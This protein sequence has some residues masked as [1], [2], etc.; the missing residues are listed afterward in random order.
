MR[1]HESLC[2][3]CD[4]ESGSLPPPSHPTKAYAEVPFEGAWARAMH[5]FKYRGQLA[6]AGPLGRRWALSPRWAEPWEAIVPIP[7]HW[8]RRVWRGFNQVELL[9][10]ATARARPDVGARVRPA[11]LKRARHGPAQARLSAEARSQAAEGAFVVP[12][13]CYA[14]VQGRR[15]LVVDDVITTGS[16]LRAA[17]WAL[18]A[19]GAQA[20]AGMALMQAL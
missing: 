6:L 8:R 1:P 10:Q 19:A 12:A 13:S 16:T 5:A 15:I 3:A 18:H 7:L 2:S 4:L 11:W 9:L 14:A 20:T 17:R